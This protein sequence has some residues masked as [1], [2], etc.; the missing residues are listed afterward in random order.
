MTNIFLD[1][2]LSAENPSTVLVEGDP[3]KNRV[4]QVAEYEFRGQCKTWLVT[5]ELIRATESPDGTWEYGYKV[6]DTKEA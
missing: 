3:A 4:G 6:L 5:A 1:R 2:I